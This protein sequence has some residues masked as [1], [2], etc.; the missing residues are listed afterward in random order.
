MLSANLYLKYKIRWSVKLSPFSPVVGCCVKLRSEGDCCT[1]RLMHRTWSLLSFRTIVCVFSST[2]L[3]YI[4]IYISTITHMV[5]LT[6]KW[7]RIVFN[8]TGS[9]CCYYC[10]CYYCY[11]LFY[12]LTPSI[13]IYF[14]SKRILLVLS[15]SVQLKDFCSISVYGSSSCSIAPRKIHFHRTTTTEQRLDPIQCV[16]HCTPPNGPFYG[17]CQSGRLLVANNQLTINSRSRRGARNKTEATIIFLASRFP[18]SPSE[19]L[20]KCADFQKF[21]KHIYSIRATFILISTE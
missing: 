3:I 20:S 12:R 19:Y 4:F 6:P 15:L 1:T 2:L 8:L 18:F 21:L 11:L 5:I 17:E 7:Y 13:L 16:L 10:S 14:I 9:Y